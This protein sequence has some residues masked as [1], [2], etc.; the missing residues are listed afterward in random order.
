MS[1]KAQELVSRKVSTSRYEPAFI[2][3]PGVMIF[4]IPNVQIQY[5]EEKESQMRQVTCI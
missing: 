4:E 5:P 2:Q 1:G 3:G